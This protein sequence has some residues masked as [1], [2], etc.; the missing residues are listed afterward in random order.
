MAPVVNPGQR[1]LLVW[2]GQ[3][4]PEAM[5]QLAEQ[6]RETV[7]SAGYVAV[8][9]AE[10]LHMAGHPGSSFDV[11]LSGWL[12]DPPPQHSE[13]LLDQL[14]QLLRPGGQLQLRDVRGAAVS[15]Q[16]LLAGYTGSSGSGDG[17][18]ANKPDFE[19]GSSAPLRLPQAAPSPAAA[20]VWTLSSSDA[21]DDDLELVDEDEL[22]DEQDRQ[23]PDPASLR[24]CGT[25]GKR[26]ACKDCSCGLAE[27]LDAGKQPATKSVTSSCGSCF[28]GDAFRCASC[29]YLGMPAFKSGEKVQLSQRQLNADA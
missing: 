11:A 23:K 4:D 20:A 21:L 2:Q 10:R 24:V 29:P 1:V 15:R 27:E 9:N 28:L 6:L 22:L 3:V 26:K 8:E 5:K 19:V 14:L 18:T 17:V 13:Q 16:L 12:G 7:G 25:T